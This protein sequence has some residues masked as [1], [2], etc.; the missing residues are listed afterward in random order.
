MAPSVFTATH[1][2]FELA[3]QQDMTVFASAGDDGAALPNC[4]GTGYIKSVSTPASDPLVT[5]VGGTHLYA[6]YTTGV[7]YGETVWNN[8]G[9]NPDFAGGGGFSTIYPR[10]SYQNSGADRQHLPRCA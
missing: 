10:P 3:E 5:G 1:Q 7:Y 2:A 9:Q 6:N 4:A 8:S